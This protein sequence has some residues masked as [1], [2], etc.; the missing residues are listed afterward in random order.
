MHEVNNYFKFR[1][2]SIVAMFSVLQLKA[3][4]LTSQSLNW[5]AT[6][7]S[8]IL[9]LIKTAPQWICTDIRTTFSLNIMD[10]LTSASWRPQHPCGSTCDGRGSI[11]PVQVCLFHP[12]IS[13]LEFNPQVPSCFFLQE[14]KR[15]P[16]LCISG[17]L[18][19]MLAEGVSPAPGKVW[20]RSQKS[21][22]MSV[23]LKWE[24]VNRNLDQSSSI[25]QVILIR[26][27]FD[28]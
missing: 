7:W 17:V 18:D 3:A 11:I 2:Q 23:S 8:L 26:R 6:K 27:C 4:V 16:R 9:T 1:N 24:W 21:L 19:W 22:L 25:Q 13:K 5:F 12:Q 14:Y 15:E 28:C 20:E 10:E